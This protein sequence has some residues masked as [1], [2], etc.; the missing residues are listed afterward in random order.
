MEQMLLNYTSGED[1][2]K[3]EEWMKQRWG[4]DGL[5]GNKLRATEDGGERGGRGQESGRKGEMR[6]EGDHQ[7]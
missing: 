5:L 7:G 4:D 2:E 1:W 3:F 6:D